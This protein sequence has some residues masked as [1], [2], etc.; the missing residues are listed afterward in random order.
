[1]EF[2]REMIGEDVYRKGIASLAE[3]PEGMR[4]ARWILNFLKAPVAAN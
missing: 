1:M 2:R 3:Q 4:V